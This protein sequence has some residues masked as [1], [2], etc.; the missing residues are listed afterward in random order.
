LCW[1][2]RSDE[3][4]AWVRFHSLPDS[5]RYPENEAEEGIILS[6]AYSLGNTT[7]GMGTSCWQIECRAKELNP[8]YW[9]APVSGVKAITFADDEEKLWCAHVLET[10]WRQDTLDAILLAVAD[11]KTGPTMWMARNTGKIFAPYDGGFDLLVSSPE[12]VEQL[13]AQFGEWLSDHPEGL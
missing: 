5:K 7:L 10:H 6:R 2:L 3:S 1:M 12:E 4:L 13:K 8:P 11:D 9:D